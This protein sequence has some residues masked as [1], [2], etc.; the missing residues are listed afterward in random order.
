V[1]IV[2]EHLF[3]KYKGP[4]DYLAVPVEE[5]EADIRPTGFFRNKTK[6]LRGMS[7]MVLDDFR[8]EIPRSMNEMIRLPGVGRKT[9]NV[10]LHEIWGIESGIAVDTHVRRVAGRLGLSKQADP[11]KIEQDLMKLIP[12]EGWGDLSHRLIFHGRKTCKARKPQCAECVLA[13]ICPSA[14]KV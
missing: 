11:D 7:A 14:F 8:G 1:N 12:Y 9:A 13:D 4:E 2:T 3:K 6:S 5:L 10:V